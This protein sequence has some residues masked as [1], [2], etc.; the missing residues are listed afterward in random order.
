MSMGKHS[1]YILLKVLQYQKS[2]GE[3][4]CF[5]IVEWIYC[6]LS[7]HNMSSCQNED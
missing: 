5:L 6:I 1:L 2:K 4:I 7:G 3:I